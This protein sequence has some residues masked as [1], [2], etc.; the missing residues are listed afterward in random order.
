MKIVTITPR[1]LKAVLSDLQSL[2]YANLSASEQEICDA[3]DSGR[4]DLDNRSDDAR[5]RA[6]EDSYSPQDYN[7]TDGVQTMRDFA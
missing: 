3:F 7:D 6:F 4:L 2:G 1:R 5:R